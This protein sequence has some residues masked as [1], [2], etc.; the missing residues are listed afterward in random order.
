[1]RKKLVRII[2]PVVVAGS[3]LVGVG[4]E[5]ASAEVIPKPK[6]TSKLVK[7]SY[8]RYSGMVWHRWTYRV[9]KTY[10]GSHGQKIRTSCKLKSIDSALGPDLS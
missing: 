5:T 7:Q 1:M 2:L 3:L 8:P 6:T 9:C 4:V 10:Y